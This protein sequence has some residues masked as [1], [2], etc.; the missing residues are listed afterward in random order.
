[1]QTNDYHWIRI[2]GLNN[3]IMYD[4]L[5]LDKNTWYHVKKWLSLIG[6]ILSN[7]IYV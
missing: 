3:I 7:H 4:L 2:V 1:M 5:V 6:R